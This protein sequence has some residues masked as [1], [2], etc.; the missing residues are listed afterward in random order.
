MASVCTVEEASLVSSD[1][2]DNVS[3]LLDKDNNLEKEIF[4]FLIKYFHF[5]LWEKTTTNQALNHP[6]LGKSYLNSKLLYNFSADIY[7]F[8]VETKTCV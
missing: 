7:L 3:N 6:K 1:D 4:H 8:K 5:Q 2:L